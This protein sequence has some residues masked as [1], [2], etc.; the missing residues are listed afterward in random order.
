MSIPTVTILAPFAAAVV[1]ALVLRK[2]TQ[3][4][5]NREWAAVVAERIREAEEIAYLERKFAAKS[6]EGR[7]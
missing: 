7:S 5:E 6:A 1:I 4:G 2:L 3:R